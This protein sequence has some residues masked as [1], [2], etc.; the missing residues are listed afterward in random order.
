MKA[1]GA[2][3]Y[4]K[5]NRDPHDFAIM[6]AVAASAGARGDARTPIFIVS[7]TEPLFPIREFMRQ[8]YN[9]EELT[10]CVD[11]SCLYQHAKSADMMLV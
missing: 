9:G 1:Q 6:F 2:K 11:A 8:E 7:A 4:L 3:K 10:F 5:G